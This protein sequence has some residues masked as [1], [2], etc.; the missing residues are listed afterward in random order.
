VFWD[1]VT[2][3]SKE[4]WLCE[5][6]QDCGFDP[7]TFEALNGRHTIFDQYH[8]FEHGQRV[9]LWKRQFS[10]LVAFLADEAVTRLSDPAPELGDKLYAAMQTFDTAE[11]NEE[12]ARVVES[13]RR[14][15]EY[16]IGR[17]FPPVERSDTGQG[18]SARKYRNRLLA[19]ADVSHRSD[20]DID[21]V[22]ASTEVW[23][24]QVDKLLNMTNK[25]IHKEVCRAETRRTLLRTI[26]LLDEIISLH[27]APFE[28]NDHTDTSGMIEM[29]NDLFTK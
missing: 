10:Y 4:R 22:V 29:L 7:V 23:T 28:V 11:T 18:L 13:C 27:T 25:G 3:D 1:G 26:L 14:I 16:V 12:L 9:A 20:P 17:I 15:F 2:E 21:L 24:S 19:Y 6:L 5:F 8:N